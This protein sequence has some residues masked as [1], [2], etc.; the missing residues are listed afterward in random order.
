MEYFYIVIGQIGI[1]AVYVFIGICLIKT[2]ILN[3]D[4]LGVMSKLISKLTLPLLIFVSTI[5]GANQEQF[6]AALPY[7]PYLS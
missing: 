5:D 3:Y 7:I 2:H 4:G 1:F 6:I